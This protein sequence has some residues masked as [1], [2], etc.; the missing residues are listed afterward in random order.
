[1]GGEG[2]GREKGEGRERGEQVGPKGLYFLGKT[3]T[4][5]PKACIN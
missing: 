1:M 2:E 5:D 4:C 3:I